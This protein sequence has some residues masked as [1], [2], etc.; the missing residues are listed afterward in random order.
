MAGLPVSPGVCGGT[1]A[2]GG[3]SYRVPVQSVPAAQSPL[4]IMW[5]NYTPLTGRLR[6]PNQP[7]TAVRSV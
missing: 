6:C 7:R 1:W 3:L 2:M 5:G 4:N